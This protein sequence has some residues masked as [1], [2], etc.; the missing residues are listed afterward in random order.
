M[1]DLFL[2]AT[3]AG[4]ARLTYGIRI[5]LH[6]RGTLDVAVNAAITARSAQPGFG[7]AT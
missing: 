4:A 5:G 7:R 3:C 6:H 1:A 2:S